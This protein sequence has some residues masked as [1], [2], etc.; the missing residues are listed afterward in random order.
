MNTE[1][2]MLIE[3]FFDPATW[4]IS[5]LLLDVRTGDCALIDSVLDY[6]PKS[7]RTGTTAAER[8]IGRVHELG[9]K[10]QWLLETHVHAYHLSA[11]PYLKERLGGKL[12]I[13]AHVTR[14]QEVVGK[15]FNA[16]SQVRHGGS[17]VHHPRLAG[18][19]IPAGASLALA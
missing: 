3:G 16:G 9:A 14:V 13:G 1:S 5:Y 18:E 7:G 6:D 2:S 15:L 11:A 8:L 4:T 19:T 12:A 17:Q 10:I